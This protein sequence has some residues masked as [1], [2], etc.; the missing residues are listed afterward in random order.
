MIEIYNSYCIITKND[1]QKIGYE[2]YQR[3]IKI[4]KKDN[5]FFILAYIQDNTQYVEIQEDPH[6]FTYIIPSHI[7]KLQLSNCTIDFTNP[8]V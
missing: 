4:K 7:R 1:I 5:E 2:M 6:V 3:E 8:T